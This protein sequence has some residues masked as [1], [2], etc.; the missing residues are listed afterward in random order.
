MED[1]NSNVVLIDVDRLMPYSPSIRV[2]VGDVEPLAESFKLCGVLEPLVVRPFKGEIGKFEVVCGARRLSAALKAGLKAVPCVV[3]QMDD[4]EAM[5][6]MITENLQ[7][8]NLTDYE[9]GRWF[10]LLLDKGYC[11]NQEALSKKFGYSAE[12]VSRL[13]H[14]YESVEKWWTKAHP[15]IL[16]RVKALPE[17]FTREVR[18]APAELQPKILAAVVRTVDK[19]ERGELPHPPGVRDIADLVESYIPKWKPKA[20]EEEETL[21][22]PEKPELAAEPK[23]ASAPTVEKPPMEKPPTTPESLTEEKVEEK[24]KTTMEKRRETQKLREET[25]VVH[26]YRFYPENFLKDVESMCGQDVPIEKVKKLAYYA[27]EVM[28]DQLEPEAKMQV[29]REAWSWMEE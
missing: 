15:N 1:L 3:R 24:L 23:P 7:R 22:A 28:W 8:E 20:E 2:E 21:K 27:I 11:P 19:H 26:L 18:R 14:H 4:R 10:K 17:R 13:I 16:T 6:A 9:V 29:L 12:M 5:E 25:L